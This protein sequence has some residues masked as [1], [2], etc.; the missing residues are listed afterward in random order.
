MA[1]MRP[2][3]KAAGEAQAMIIKGLLESCGIPSVIR[4]GVAPSVH[5]FTVD[6]VGEYSI[7]VNESDF[8]EAR[9][10]IVTTRTQHR[11]P[12]GNQTSQTSGTRHHCNAT[13]SVLRPPLDAVA[14]RTRHRCRH[15]AVL[16]GLPEYQRHSGCCERP[17]HASGMSY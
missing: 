10:L 7:M 3:Y 17:G 2:V 9:H 5:V 14:A 6:G 11:I 16:A 4:S 15:H 13:A 8:E 12:S 1:K